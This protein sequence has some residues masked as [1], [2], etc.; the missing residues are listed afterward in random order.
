MKPYEFLV[1]PLALNLFAYA[2][3]SPLS[4]ADPLGL[5][6]TTVG[7]TAAQSAAIQKAAQAADAASQTCLPCEDRQPFRSVIRS[8]GTSDELVFRCVPWNMNPGTGLFVCGVAKIKAGLRSVLLTPTGLAEDPGCPCLES[9]VLHEV[10]HHIGYNEK[11]AQE[12]EE[13]CFR[14]SGL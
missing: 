10:S 14:C 9:L 2:N 11:Q 12:A 8:Q 3:S 1:R 5:S 4:Y 7:C 13:R 6:V